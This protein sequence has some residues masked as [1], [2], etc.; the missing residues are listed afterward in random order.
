VTSEERFAKFEARLGKLGQE[1]AALRA[2]VKGLRA[3][4]AALKAELG[5]K[6]VARLLREN[7]YSLQATHK[8]VEGKQHPDRDAQFK[9]INRK[10]FGARE[11]R[12]VFALE[13]RPRS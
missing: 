8:T 9:H 7:G 2:E 5:D 10:A 11:D 1:N 13:N 12:P 3:E 6:T 4:N